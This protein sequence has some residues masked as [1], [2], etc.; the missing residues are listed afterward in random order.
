MNV[1]AGSCC[2]QKRAAA[3]GRLRLAGSTQRLEYKNHLE[4]NYCIEG[5]GEVEEVVT[6]RIWPL[7]PGTMYVL[8][9]HDAHIIRAHTDMR[10]L[11]VFTPALSGTETH[12]ADGSYNLP[13]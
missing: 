8:D 10:L 2:G 3:A 11:C 5:E 13:G 4:A 1:I 7:E 9:A 6:G 12:D